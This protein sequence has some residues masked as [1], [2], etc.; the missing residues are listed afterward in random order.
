MTLWDIS[1]NRLPFIRGRPQTPILVLTA[2]H[3]FTSR[4]SPFAKGCHKKV[5]PSI[6]HINCLDAKKMEKEKEKEKVLLKYIYEREQKR[7]GWRYD[8]ERGLYINVESGRGS[9]SFGA[10]NG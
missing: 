3:D 4:L 1:W 9:H 8:S 5:P 10:L 6:L 2:R 7:W